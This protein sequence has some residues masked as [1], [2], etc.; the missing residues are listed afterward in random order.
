[1]VICFY[2]CVWFCRKSHSQMGVAK[3]INYYY[4]VDQPLSQAVLLSLVQI[5]HY[6]HHQV[7]LLHH[8]I[9][10]CCHA[11]F[12]YSVTLCLVVWV[13][14]FPYDRFVSSACTNMYWT[15]P[16]TTSWYWS[17][18]FG[19]LSHYWLAYLGSGISFSIDYRLYS[20]SCCCNLLE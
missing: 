7:C 15:C 5:S 19:I 6:C 2:V 20:I 13:S 3:R 1:M 10:S 16:Y 14:L 8:Q 18:L 17:V 12:R 4:L 11:L 9:R